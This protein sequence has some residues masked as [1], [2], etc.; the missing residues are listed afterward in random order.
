MRTMTLGVTDGK[1]QRAVRNPFLVRT[2]RLLDLEPP[3]EY[4]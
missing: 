3:P 1:L 2:C 4:L